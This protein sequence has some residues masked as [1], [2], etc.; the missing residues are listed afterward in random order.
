VAKSKPAKKRTTKSY[1][2]KTQPRGK[3]G[4]FTKK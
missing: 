1:R 2:A 4:K 3:S